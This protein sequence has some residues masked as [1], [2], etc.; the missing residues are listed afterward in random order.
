VV[1]ECVLNALLPVL[2]VVAENVVAGLFEAW[3]DCGANRTLPGLWALTLAPSYV[4]REVVKQL[5]L[6]CFRGAVGLLGA[7]GTQSM[8]HRGF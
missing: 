5:L 4:L 6:V 2:V 1:T 7:F 3:D 8:G